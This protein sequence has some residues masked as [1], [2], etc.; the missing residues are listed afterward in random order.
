MTQRNILPTMIILVLSILFFT[1]TYS[2]PETAVTMVSSAMFPRIILGVII[3]MTMI[4]L[5]GDIRKRPLP[6]VQ[7][8][9]V[10]VSL[11]IVFLLLAVMLGLLKWVGFVVAATV[12]MTLFSLFMT[13]NWKK[14]LDILKTFVI[15]LALSLGIYYLFVKV[16]MFV[17]P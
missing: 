12:F 8:E 13:G 11:L 3:A 1:Q 9:P 16:L 15:N 4:Q 5:Y 2:I 6:S 17:L 7:R 10:H 14:P